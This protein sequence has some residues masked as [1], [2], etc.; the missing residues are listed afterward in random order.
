MLSNPH[1]RPDVIFHPEPLDWLVCQQSHSALTGDESCGQRWALLSLSFSSFFL[2]VL[3][4][5]GAR[6]GDL[7]QPNQLTPLRARPHP[8]VS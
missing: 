2:S 6:A 5:V 1:I 7:I 3:P 4:R 8:Q